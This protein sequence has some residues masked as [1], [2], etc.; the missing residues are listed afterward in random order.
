MKTLSNIKK[1]PVEIAVVLAQN[2]T[3]ARLLLNDTADALERSAPEHDLNFLIQEH[4]IS[5]F[6]PVENRI[7]QYGRNNFISILLDTALDAGDNNTRS[8]LVIYVSTDEEHL[9]LNENKNRLLEMCDKINSLLDGKKLTTSG[10]L[11]ITSFSHVMLSEFH[12]S[13][14]IS[15]NISDQ[16]KGNSDI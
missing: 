2:E 11:R 10:E 14:R 5:F 13:Y 4:Y 6:P 16:K 7:E 1:I 3:I 15:A 9:L 8:N 12:S